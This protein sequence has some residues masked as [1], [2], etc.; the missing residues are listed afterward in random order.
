[1]PIEMRDGQAAGEVPVRL[2]AV[3]GR[4]ALGDY[5]LAAARDHLGVLEKYFGSPYPYPKLD[6]LAVPNFAAG[7]MENPGLITF[8]EERLLLD[9]NTASTAMRRAVAG[10]IAH[11][12][13]HM[14]FGDLVTLAWWND[15]W[16]NEGF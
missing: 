6:L 12:L 9:P 14:W 10:V 7:A 2:G 15:I 1:G 4:S 5:G 16:L 3:A 8:R 13:A 11:E